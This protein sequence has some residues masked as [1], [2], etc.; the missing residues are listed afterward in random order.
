MLLIEVP[1]YT[2][3]AIDLSA[4]T[5]TP[6]VVAADDTDIIVMLL[7]HWREEFQEVT[8]CQDRGLRRDG[9]SKLFHHHWNQSE[10]ICFLF[11][12]GPVATPSQHRV[13]TGHGKPGKAGKAGRGLILGKSW[14]I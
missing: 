5:P 8:F 1:F 10:N 9:A 7:C 13:P 2:E 12:H 6:N 3:S 4:S 14:K 11:M